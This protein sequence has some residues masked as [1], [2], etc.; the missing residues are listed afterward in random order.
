MHDLEGFA[1]PEIAHA[2]GIP[3]NTGYSRLRLAREELA[4]AVRRL[5]RE[6]GAA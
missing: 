5:R 4:D 3:L 2:L 1:M 6:A